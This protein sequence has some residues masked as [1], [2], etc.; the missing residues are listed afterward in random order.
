MSSPRKEHPFEEMVIKASQDTYILNDTDGN[1]CFGRESRMQVLNK[2]NETSA[3]YRAA[4]FR[5]DLDSQA[6]EALER[7]KTAKLRVYVMGCEL[8]PER[9]R[10]EMQVFATKADWTEE[11]LNYA[12]RERL[13]ARCTRLAQLPYEDGTYITVDILP[14]LLAQKTDADGNLSVSFCL[15]QEDEHPDTL[16]TFLSS[17]EGR[18][19][20]KIEIGDGHGQGAVREL[21][22]VDGPEPWQVAR[23]IVDEWFDRVAP[24]V[25][26]KDENGRLLE[27]ELFASAS[28]GYG[29][30]SPTGDF[31]QEI[32]W[33]QG[34]AWQ[35]Y[36]KETDRSVWDA[37]CY[38]R[39]LKIF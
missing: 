21:A 30:K 33:R 2:G 24:V 34:V 26:A 36:G 35:V 18:F 22:E 32:T 11:T 7:A 13:A 12:T 14:Y 4:Y 5:F 9:R 1:A 28:C 23:E 37:R 27:H 10:Y 3:L 25:Y 19:P 6:L 8:N 39:T 31:T 29:A 16:L 38:A 17:R 20:P 15:T